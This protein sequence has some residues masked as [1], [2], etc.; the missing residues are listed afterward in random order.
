M[1]DHGH[2]H[3]HDDGGDDHGGDDHGGDDHGGH[4]HGGHTHRDDHGHDHGGRGHSH[5][6]GPPPTGA[7]TAFA[8]ASLLNLAYVAVEILYGLVAHSTALLADAAHNAGDVLGLL[9]AWGA[10]ALA[11][12]KRSPRRTY[13]LRSTTL[14]AALTNS[15]LI[16]VASGGVAW[17]AIKRIG[18][19]PAVHGGTV[20]IVAIVGVAINGVSAALFTRRRAHDANARAAFLHLLSDALVG[21]AVAVAGL[22]VAWTGAR[23]LDP[24]TSLVVTAVILIGTVALLR[25][26]ANL[27]LAGVPGHIELSKVERYLA[28]LPGVC[29]VH[30]LHVWPISTTEIALTAHLVLPWP[31]AAPG[32]LATV[33]HELDRRFGIGHAT[34]QLEASE[35]APCSRDHD[36]AV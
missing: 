35:G 36:E 12:V 22:L 29:G 20:A 13:G 8:L 26:T 19:T 25:E 31:A 33:D 7:G 4:A 11:G 21:V 27:A 30:D 15:L 10:A 3:D 14:Y 1:A 28:S 5:S 34:I 9:L 16:V 18:T 23:W 17:E 24:A 2:G 6:H 32:F